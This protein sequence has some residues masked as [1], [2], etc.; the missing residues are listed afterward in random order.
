MRKR[1]HAVRYP[2]GTGGITGEFYNH[3]LDSGLV[4]SKLLAKVLDGCSTPTEK[5]NFMSALLAQPPTDQ[6]REWIEAFGI[7]WRVTD[8]VARIKDHGIPV[9]KQKGDKFASTL[10]VVTCDDPK[11]ECHTIAKH[12][13]E[14]MQKFGNV[15][16]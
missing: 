13:E 15:D 14:S 11:C 2:P 6:Q 5:V 12:A 16:V 10:E 1:G 4:D 3:I 7:S 9:W 8:V